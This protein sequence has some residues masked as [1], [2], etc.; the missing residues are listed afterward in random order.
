MKKS[1]GP[2]TAE[3][4]LYG[5]KEEKKEREGGRRRK[6]KEKKDRIKEA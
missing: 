6:K 2:P 3:D 4:I 5:F 1:R